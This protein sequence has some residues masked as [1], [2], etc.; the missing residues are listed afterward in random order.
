VT[1]EPFATPKSSKPV[2]RR[3]PKS[4]RILRAREFREVYDKGLRVSGALVA[5]FCLAKPGQTGP[6]LGI[7]TPKSLGGSVVRNRLRRRLREIFRLHSADFG[8]G[9]DIVL[10]PR[11]A[12]G[13]APFQEL[14]R[15]FQR[16]IARCG[17]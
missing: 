4:S 15:E 11:R 9:W 16:V 5:A 13:D 7:T 1:R 17:N 3:F 14:V 6:R 10:N 12:A 2:S 8:G